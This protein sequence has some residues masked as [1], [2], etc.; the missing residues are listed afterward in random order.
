[1]T[2][3]FTLAVALTTFITAGPADARTPVR[4]VKSTITAPKGATVSIRL[5]AGTSLKTVT[6]GT[7]SAKRGTI[8]VRAKGYENG[9]DYVGRMGDFAIQAGTALYGRLAALY[10]SLTEAQRW[11]MVGVTPMLGIND[12]P[13]ETF[14]TADAQKVASWATTQHIGMVGMWALGRDTACVWPMPAGAGC[15]G[16]DQTPYAFAKALGAF[17]G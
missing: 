4:S 14:T 9:V 3:V 15:S 5:A 17:T 2:R 6:G 8:A 11:R 13:A 10:P 1:V 7:A 12:D 16:V